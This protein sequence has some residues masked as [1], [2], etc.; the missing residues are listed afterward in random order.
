MDEPAV[1]RIGGGEAAFFSSRAPDA[2]RRN[3]DAAAL[4]PIDGG[5]CVLAVADGLGGSLA[6]AQASEAAVR[7]LAEALAPGPRSGGMLRTAILNGFEAANGSVR[8]L[9][10]GAGTTLAVAEVQEDVIRPYHAGD[11]PILLIGQRGRVKLQTVDHSPVGFAV[12]AGLLDAD[13]ALH[14]EDRHIISNFVGG[15]D[16]RIEMGS[17]LH[18]AERDTL[19]LASD[20]LADNLRTDEIAECIRTGSL[21]EAADAL[22]QAA[23]QRMLEPV[24]EAPSKPDDLT[25]VLYRRG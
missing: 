16:L 8:D 17:G 22:A 9:G 14:H 25:F 20:G 5:S 2:D 18:L 19:C 23:R 15:A 12:E 11:S 1:V 6:G 7:S 13:A 10:V 3:E 4:L 24:A 21:A